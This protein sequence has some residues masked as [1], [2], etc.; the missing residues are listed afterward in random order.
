MCDDDAV[1][2]RLFQ[3]IRYTVCKLQEFFIVETFRANL[4]DLL[5]SYICDLSHFRD[6]SDNLIDC[7]LGH[8]YALIFAAEDPAPAIVPPVPMMTMFGFVTSRACI[9]SGPNTIGTKTITIV[10]NR[11]RIPRRDA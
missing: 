6:S 1:D 9:I 3:Q 11:A 8:L 7:N 4:K 5:T 10:S 2:V